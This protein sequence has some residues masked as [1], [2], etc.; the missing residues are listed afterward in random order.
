[1]YWS[2]KQQLAHHSING[3]NMQTGDLLGSGTISGPTPD[4]LGSILEM[5]LNGKNPMT[6]DDGVVRTF[7]ED[8]DEVVLKGHCGNGST[9]L[10]FG[11]AAGI[12]HPSPFDNRKPL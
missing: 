9:G 12:I 8:G 6:L 3:C 2:F 10:G 4:S 11:V 7:L 5:T 1:M